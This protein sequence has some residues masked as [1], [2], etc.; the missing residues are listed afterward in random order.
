ML[1]AEYLAGI[2]STS[3][4]L[5][6]E[7]ICFSETSIDFQPITR[8]YVQLFIITALKTSNAT[9]YLSVLSHAVEACIDTEVGLLLRRINTI[10][11]VKNY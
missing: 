11:R 10:W 2:F 1:Q 6:M 3:S 8:R 7:V 5:K 9:Q 4:T